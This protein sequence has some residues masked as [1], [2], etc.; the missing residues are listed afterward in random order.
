MEYLREGDLA[1]HIN[2]PLPQESVQNISKQL[3]EGLKVIHQQGI[4]HRDLK[5]TV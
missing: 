2:T 1:K 5:P 4:A 3:L